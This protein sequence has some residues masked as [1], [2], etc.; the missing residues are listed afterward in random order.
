MAQPI[1][2]EPA[3]PLFPVYWTEADLDTLP[4]DGHRYEVLEGSLLMTPPPNG[5]HQN[6]GMKLGVALVTAAPDG[7]HVLYESGVRLPNGNFVP[8]LIALPPGVEFRKN[9]H[10]AADV[11]LVVEIAS[12]STD[13]VDRGVKT[14][15]YAKAGIPSYW[16]LDRDGSIIVHE[17]SGR[18]YDVAAVIRSGESAEITQP[19][20]VTLSPDDLLY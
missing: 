3:R 17:L 15:Q 4:K 19:Y 2:A 8:D 9:W 7:W 6:S 11:A 20:P 16:R 12:P 18:E 14:E 13:W 1:P 10:D 5:G